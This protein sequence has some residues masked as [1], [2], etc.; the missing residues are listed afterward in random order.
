MLP[1]AV[2][3]GFSLRSFAYPKGCGFINADWLSAQVPKRPYVFIA[4]G[5]SLRI[6]THPEGCGY[7]G[8]RTS[9]A[10]AAGFSLRS[11]AHPEGCGY[12]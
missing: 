2:A 7:I 9:A 11:F 8:F 6:F 3:A 1:Q 10:V 4:A 5:F 12:I